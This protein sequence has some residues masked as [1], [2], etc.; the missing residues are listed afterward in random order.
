MTSIQN[1]ME[2]RTAAPSDA[3]DG[4]GV[5]AARPYFD[6]HPRKKSGA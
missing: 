5:V 6:H 2:Q 4:T 1:A 3:L